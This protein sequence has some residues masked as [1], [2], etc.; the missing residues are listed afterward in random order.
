M[1]K[2]LFIL[3]MILAAP[4][5]SRGSALTVQSVKGTAEVRHG[6]ME[7]W[8]KLKAGDKL[9]PEDT[10]RTGPGSTVTV[11]VGTRRIQIP[12]ETMLDVVD[13]RTMSQ[14]ELLLKLAME[15][16]LKVPPREVDSLMIPATTL[17]HG[18]EIKSPSALKP[19]T[20]TDG[21]MQ[22]KGAKV[23]Y[24]YGYLETSVLRAKEVM[25]SFK[26]LESQY[27]ARLRVARAFERLNLKREALREYVA[28]S[29]ESLPPTARREVEN[30]IRRLKRM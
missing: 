1:T 29:N 25:R 27:D 15:D 26:E 18:T 22:L 17:L 10:I 30:A 8:K 7:E 4:V 13:F 3:L 11:A 6:V 14:E 23:L 21:K 28:L 12:P 2:Q 24:D 19:T 9:K 20:L 5:L 16:V